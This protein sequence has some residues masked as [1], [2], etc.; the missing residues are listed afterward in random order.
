MFIFA[1]MTTGSWIGF[2]YSIGTHNMAGKILFPIIAITGSIVSAAVS[3]LEPIEL[4]KY[5]WDD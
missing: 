1:I 3:L 4:N 2:G 5:E